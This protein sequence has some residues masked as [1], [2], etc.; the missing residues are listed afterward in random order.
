MDIRPKQ[1]GDWIHESPRHEP[2]YIEEVGQDDILPDNVW[3]RQIQSAYPD[4]ISYDVWPE[5]HAIEVP[6]Q[7]TLPPVVVERAA[8]IIIEERPTV[9]TAPHIAA[10]RPELIIPEPVVELSPWARPPLRK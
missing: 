4:A 3:A 10:A 6:V 1:L 7:E 5:P 2:G 8:P 9:F